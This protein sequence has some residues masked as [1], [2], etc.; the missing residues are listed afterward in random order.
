MTYAPF[1]ALAA[2]AALVPTP[3]QAVT[4]AECQAYLCLPGGFPPPECTPAKRAVI[5]RL[6]SGKPALPPWSSCASAFGWDMAT[7]SHTEPRHYD[8]PAGGTLSG[9][10]C[11]YTDAQRCTW[12]YTSREQATVQVVVDGSTSFSPNHTLTH[13]TRSAGTPTL[14]PG[15]NPRICRPRRPQCGTP[16]NPPCPPSSTCADPNRRPSPPV[17]GTPARP[18]GSAYTTPIASRP[19]CICP[20]NYPFPFFGNRGWICLPNPGSPVN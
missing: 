9:Q 3:S 20:G 11:R 17:P 1:I 15:Q 7:L 18:P 14:D 5:A 10:T 2:L 12:S 4:F 8:C 13:T 16:G 19:A 6:M